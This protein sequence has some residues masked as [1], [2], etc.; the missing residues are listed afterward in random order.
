MC[1]LVLVPKR[2]LLVSKAFIIFLF[3]IFA[4]I[5]VTRPHGFASNS[6]FTLL[7]DPIKGDCKTTKVFDVKFIDVNA[8]GYLDL[9]SH[10]H[11]GSNTTENCLALN[12]GDGTF[13][14]YSLGAADLGYEGSPPG[15]RIGAFRYE[16]IDANGDGLDEVASNNVGGGKAKYVIN[17]TVSGSTKPSFSEKQNRCGLPKGA[18]CSYGFLRQK[19]PMEVVRHDRSS[20]EVISG[21]TI[22]RATSDNANRGWSIIDLN[23]DSWPDL[24]AP[25]LHKCYM[26]SG[27]KLNSASQTLSGLNCSSSRK[28]WA[29]ID[30]DGDL[31]LYCSESR[32]GNKKSYAK[33]CHKIYKN[34]NDFTFT[35]V[36]PQSVDNM[37]WTEYWTQYG[38]AT[39]TDVNNDGCSDLLLAGST[40]SKGGVAVLEG[41]CKFGFKLQFRSKKQE[42]SGCK[43]RVHAKDFDYDGLVD[44]VQVAS[45]NSRNKQKTI[46]KGFDIYKNTRV[47][48]YKYLSINVVGEGANTNGLHT[49]IDVYVPGSTELIKY[50][51][52]WESFD[53]NNTNPVHIG[54]GENEYVDVRVTWPHG[55]GSSIF[56]NVQS[57][58]CIKVEFNDGEPILTK[59]HVPCGL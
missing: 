2:L 49:S 41:D 40:R 26:N 52:M 43:P 45:N 27:G 50:E 6:S 31:D 55:R 47:T 57:G 23:R 14:K 48:D 59:N 30:N 16:V 29:D 37:K 44:F 32:C 10:R 33:G 4:L 17:K 22:L 19:Q 39:F 38:N 54:V 56:A 13:I 58:Q 42:V 9:L 34:N 5:Y 28:S 53:T 15:T 35:E 7:A 1:A 3:V 12:N 8:D 11:G 36:T 46:A 25:A 21:K 51:H 20:V 24:C 18:Y